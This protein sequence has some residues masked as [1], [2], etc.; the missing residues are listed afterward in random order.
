[1]QLATLDWIVIALYGVVA[2]AIGIRY[3]KRAGSSVDEYFVS[4]RTLPW[5]LAGTSMVATSF[6]ADTPLVVTGW[7]RD[8]GLAKN[9]VWWCFAISGVL[10]AFLFARYW[11]RLEV[12]TSAELAERRYGGR[13]A[14]VLR[15]SF[16]LFQSLV[17]SVIVLSWVLL[18]AYKIMDVLLGVD[19]TTALAIACLVSLAYSLLAGFWGVVITDL[20][21]F[22]I[23]VIGA[24]LLAVSAWNGV[25]GG[26][27][28]HAAIASGVI[29]S[30]RIELWPRGGAGSI[31]DASFW[32]AAP[33]AF[34]VYLGVSWWATEAVD[35]GSYVVQRIAACRD[36]RHGMLAQLWY[37]IA[38]YALRPWPWFAVAL[39][40]LLVLPTVELR[41]PVAGIVAATS[42]DAIS[43]DAADGVAHRIALDGGDA[44]F[45][46]QPL[47][48]EGSRVAAGEVVARTDSERAYP[49][50]MAKFLP[51]GLLGLVVASLLAAL[52]STIDTYV[53]LAGSYVVNDV[54]RRFLAPNAST[55]RCIA[56]GRIVGVLV[57]A[58]AALVAA[59]AASI[60][61]LFLFSLALI[62]GV[63]AA[64]VLRWTWWRAG[65]WTEIAALF[66]SATVTLLL[67]AKP[68]AFPLG[69]LSMPGGAI[70]PEGRILLVASSSLVVAVAVTL[71]R[72]RPDPAALV[73]F[74][75]QVRPIGA[76]GP[77]RA[78]AGVAPPH[79]E[80][81]SALLGVVASLI[82]IFATLFGIGEALLGDAGWA[83]AL[84]VLAALAFAVV[85]RCV[86]VLAPATKSAL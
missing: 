24:V 75:R 8:H 84:L 38:H 63:G 17:A 10:T 5:W 74:Y 35:G 27:A 56:V 64:Y 69:P 23:A 14:A 79:A 21:Q 40:S 78:L 58:L 73:P 32:I 77:V 85:H 34:A 33:A 54:Y 28:I 51:V 82:A 70:T 29:A 1:M 81:R 83:A 25:G 61:S 19:R 62:G 4:G 72:R 47:V 9:W 71:L 18:A 13:E 52:M 86:N 30:E 26:D 65:A 67:E 12:T 50:M 42:L 55:A 60:A 46:P 43:I 39:A 57:V 2:L 48:A 16:A 44:I 80:V 6:A 22:S 31:F 41:A 7:V 37:A 76:W 53:V 59:N 49:A 3:A 20:V 45:R 15:G 66:T 36:D 11:R 68:A